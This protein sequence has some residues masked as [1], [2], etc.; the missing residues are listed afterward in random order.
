VIISCPAC[1]T[2][3]VVSPSAIS[4]EGRTV[5][6]ARCSNKWHQSGEEV[7]R[8]ESM[9]APPSFAEMSDPN[10]S[11]PVPQKKGGV[12]GW[13]K[14]ACI[15]LL[16]MVFSGSFIVFEDG[17]RSIGFVDDLYAAAGLPD[18]QGLELDKVQVQVMPGRRYTRYFITGEIQNTT[19]QPMQVAGMRVTLVDKAGEAIAY[20]DYT[21][22]DL[23]LEPGESVPFS[24]EEKSRSSRVEDVVIDLG[25]PL[26]I[27]E[28]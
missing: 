2:R 12:P 8:D 6:C 11:L 18:S 5:K 20:T 25:N 26:E 4:A 9:E 15:V 17:M 24:L 7:S 1:N 27:A 14:V 3:Y 22:E 16:F 19:E 10:H 13:L 21:Q 28:R 23:L